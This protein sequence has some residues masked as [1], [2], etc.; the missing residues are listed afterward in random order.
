MAKIVSLL[1]GGMVERIARRAPAPQRPAGPAI[2]AQAKVAAEAQITKAEAEAAK[3]HAEQLQA[4]IARATAAE[5]ALGRLSTEK[6]V[7]DTL[8]AAERAAR[9]DLEARLQA[10]LTRPRPAAPPA[11][12]VTALAR[13]EAKVDGLA[14]RPAPI[15]YSELDVRVIKDD[16]G[17]ITRFVIKP[18]VA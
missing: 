7:T 2:A 9:Q 8:L 14:S 1:T 3:R 15:K 5:D 4:A 18:K 13:M 17:A 11:V 12:D 10:E 16:L 6:A